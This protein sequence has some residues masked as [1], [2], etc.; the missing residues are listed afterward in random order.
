[1]ANVKFNVNGVSAVFDLEILCKE[2]PRS[3]NNFREISRDLDLYRDN[4][5]PLSF[6]G[7]Y[8]DSLNFYGGFVLV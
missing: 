2:L 8:I 7:V 4:F 3:E 1:V 5:D 6:D